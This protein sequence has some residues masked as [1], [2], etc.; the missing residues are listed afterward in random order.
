MGK[1]LGFKTAGDAVARSG[2][3]LDF[4]SG[5]SG[6]KK[7]ALGIGALSAL[8]LLGL[9]QEMMKKKEKHTEEKV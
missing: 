6:A 4:F 7:A 5:M 2:G 8:P 1:P 3:L 9:V